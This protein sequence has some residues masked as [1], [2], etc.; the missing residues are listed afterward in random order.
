MSRRKNREKRKTERL[1]A[2]NFEEKQSSNFKQ[3]PP[4]KP[5]NGLQESY[6]NSINRYPVTVATGNGLKFIK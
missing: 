6:I 2:P 5:M 4:L 3:P 1:P